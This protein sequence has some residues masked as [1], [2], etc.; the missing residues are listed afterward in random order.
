MSEIFSLADSLIQICS[1]VPSPGEMST[2]TTIR[3]AVR[4]AVFAACA[5]AL[6]AAQAQELGSQ[7]YTVRVRPTIALNILRPGQ[8]TN[9]PGTADDI[10]FDESLW[11][12]QCNAPAGCTLRFQSDHAFVNS[13][14]PQ[15]KRD[16]ELRIRSAFVSPFAGW[17]VDTLVDQ[18]DY[19]AGDEEAVVQ[20]SSGATG[21]A[22]VFLRIQF[23]TGDPS[24]LVGG[25]YFTTITGTISEN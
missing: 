10:I 1:S 21:L 24:A 9:H 8:V 23:M 11:L 22:F 6:Q 15:E 19:A 14:F 25:P 16:L 4:V 5:F 7:N 2:C 3:H 18:T 12:A 20:M 17:Q 13:R